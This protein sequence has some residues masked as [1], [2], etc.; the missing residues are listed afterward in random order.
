MNTN[1]KIVS[2]TSGKGGVGK[3]S[4]LV[5]IASRLAQTGKK[6]L[7]FDGDLG[8]ANVDIFY[9]VRT[10]TSIYDVLT[11]R[12]RIS[13][14]LVEVSKNIF[15]IPGGSGVLGF[16]K[17]NNFQRRAMIDELSRLPHIFDVMLIDT[18]PGI[19]DNVLYLN[20]AADQICVVLTPDPASFADSY[21]LIK[22]LHTQYKEHKFSVICNMVK[23]I[24]D[25]VSTF[26]RFNEVVER[27]LDV[28]L[29][30]IGAVPLDPLLRRANLHQRLILM[31]DQSSESAKSLVRIADCIQVR[32]KVEHRGGMKVFWEQVIGVA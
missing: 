15:L 11:G 18:A 5:N 10:D 23:D 24:R 16:N 31:Q 19:S 9:G 22:V 28:S 20:A 3:T 27:F 29:E 13:D 2:I 17:I 32:P 25:G 14:I 26:E 1:T 8:M 21:A 4:I 6:V 7:I 30:F 12:R